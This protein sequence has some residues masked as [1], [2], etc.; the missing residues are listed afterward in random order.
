MTKPVILITDGLEQAGQS[1]LAE[2]AEVRDCTGIAAEELPAALAEA[3]AVIV[4]SRTR[5]TAQVLSDAPRLKVIGRAGIGVD[6][7]D[8]NT[9]RDNHVI[10]VNT[11]VATTT[12][13]A[14]HAMTLILALARRIT[15]ADSAMKQGQWL[16]SDLMGV[17][18]SGR[19]LGIVG[20]GKIGQAVA[21]RAGSFHIKIIGFDPRS[22]VEQLRASNVEPVTLDELYARADIIS[23]HV[24]LTP[25]T[26]GMLDAAAFAAMKPGMLVV[27]TS[28]GG[29]IDETALLAA[30]ES[31]HVAGAALDVFETEPPG[32]TPLVAHPN[33]I[34][35]PHIAA[36][37][38]E[39]QVR[40]A[41]DIAT[42]VLNALK[43]EPLRW[44]VV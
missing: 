42:E 44:R 10:V 19:T 15:A 30:L 1:I 31:G 8:L 38:V 40:A 21:R 17:E 12:A 20:V 4:R 24:P 27:S 3:D 41:V 33:V 35:T 43:G 7:I 23:L 11:P 9:A 5:L 32:L 25:D 22:Q 39:A 29:V 18:L 28:R 13:V 26:E 36:Q 37:T 16:K 34:A 2:S 6:S 14:E